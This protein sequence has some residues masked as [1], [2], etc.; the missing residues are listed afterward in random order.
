MSDPSKTYAKRGKIYYEFPKG[1]KALEGISASSTKFL[2]ELIMQA[3]N[4][5]DTID[6]VRKDNTVMKV[7]QLSGISSTTK[8]NQLQ[9]ALDSIGVGKVVYAS[10]INNLIKYVNEVASTVGNPAYVNKSMP[11]EYASSMVLIKIK[12]PPMVPCAPLAMIDPAGIALLRTNVTATYTVCNNISFDC[13][14]RE[15]LTKWV[16]KDNGESYGFTF[17]CKNPNRIRP[18]QVSTGTG[19]API[20]SVTKGT[21][22]LNQT[23]ED[24]RETLEKISLGLDG[25]EGVMGT[26]SGKMFNE[27]GKCMLTCQ[28]ACQVACQIACQSCFGGTCYNKPVI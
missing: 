7:D 27:K 19:A 26:D 22:V 14:N 1:T 17:I 9:A 15:K 4:E 18:V 11:C 28:K 12:D 24:I 20:S 2:I 3:M 13:P 10:H 25:D 6:K 16:P 23:F 21:K 5:R 8:K